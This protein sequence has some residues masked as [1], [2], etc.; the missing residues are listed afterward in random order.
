MLL[1]RSIAFSTVT[2]SEDVARPKP[3]QRYENGIGGR[4]NVFVR[5]GFVVQRKG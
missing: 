4:R 2:C 3:V 1:G 5:C